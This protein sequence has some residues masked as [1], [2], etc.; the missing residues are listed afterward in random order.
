MIR[1]VFRRR[2]L[3]LILPFLL[4]A[5]FMLLFRPGNGGTA[6]IEENGR[7][8]Q[9]IELSQ[10]RE[11]SVLE[12]GGEYHVSLL[13][14]PGA[15]SFYSSDCPDQVCIRTGK[16]SAPG[17]TAVCLPARISVRITGGNGEYD[18]YTG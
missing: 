2:D 3:F 10:I 6:I 4:A 8:I 9:R 1:P 15:V 7:E 16:L 11:T 17:Q 18:G 13:L 14:E 5:L 12:L